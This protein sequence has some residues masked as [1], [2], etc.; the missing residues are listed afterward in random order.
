MEQM[1]HIMQRIDQSNTWFIIAVLVIVLLSTFAGIIATKLT[2]REERRLFQIM[3][4][5]RREDF[6]AR[7]YRDV[8]TPTFMRQARHPLDPVTYDISKHN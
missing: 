2:L 1:N 8:D 6:L 3:Q 4:D 7:L 5:K